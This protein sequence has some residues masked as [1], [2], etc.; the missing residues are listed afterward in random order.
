MKVSIITL[1]LSLTL[2]F[3]GVYLQ[4]PLPGDVEFTFLLQVILGS[5]NK[6]AVYVT[7]LGAWPLFAVP[8][9]FSL[10]L[11]F[12]WEGKRGLLFV[13]SSYSTI[14]ILDW[15]L[16]SLF[17]SPRPQSE[18]VIV[19]GPNTST[20]WPSVLGMNLGVL[21]F[22]L[23]FLSKMKRDQQKLN[24]KTRNLERIL[25]KYIPVLSILTLTI[26]GVSR[27]LLGGHWFS[28]MLSTYLLTYSVASFFYL[29]TFHQETC[30]K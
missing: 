11:G 25:L 24:S 29:K 5:F 2:G 16:R 7:M 4:G 30:Q 22:C 1:A 9:V 21:L 3:L 12:L 18:L 14:K 6:L 26:S 13:I 28:Q 8:L 19:F 23:Y 20:G 27:V 10:I 15:I 17:F